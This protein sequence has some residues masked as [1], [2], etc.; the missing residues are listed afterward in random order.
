MPF[1]QPQAAAGHY[2]VVPVPA[3]VEVLNPDLNVQPE[4]QGSG[5]T[6]FLLRDV[7]ERLDKVDTGYQ[8]NVSRVLNTAGVDDNAQIT[9][10]FDPK[11]E[12]LH[13]HSVQVRRAGKSIDELKLGRIRVLQQEDE[14]ADNIVNGALTF[15]LLLTD[16]RVGDVIDSSY[17]ID[18][19]EPAWQDKHSGSIE[20]QWSTLIRRTRSRISLPVHSTL[21]FRARPDVA[22]RVWERDGYKFY[23]WDQ[24][25]A[26]AIAF[27]RQA[28]HWIQQFGG[29]EYSQFADWAEVIRTALPLFDVSAGQSGEIQQLIARFKKASEDPQA[30]IIAAMRFVQDEIRYTGIEEGIAAY[31]P[32]P[33]Q[34]V[35]ARRFGDCKDKTLL[36][37]TLLRGLGIE[38]APALVSTHWLGETRNRLPSPQVMD[39]AIV[40]IHWAG[41]VYWFDATATG[42]GGNLDTVWQA[43]F[44]WALPIDAGMADLQAMAE[45]ELSE[46]VEEV[47]TSVDM[48][49]GKDKP[50]Q[51]KVTTVYSRNEADSMRLNLRSEGAEALAKKYLDYYQDEFDGVTSSA[52]LKVTDDRS[53]N[54]LSVEE[55]Y[56]VQKIFKK[57]ERGPS[58]LYL[59]PDS[60]RSYLV[61]PNLK[62]RTTPFSQQYPIYVAEQFE[63]LFPSDWSMSASKQHVHNAAFD[64]SSD[65]S[66]SDRRL[67]TRYEYKALSD[68]V[69][70]KDFPEFLT[71]QKKARDDAGYTVRD[72][73]EDASPMPPAAQLQQTQV[74]LMPNVV[75]VARLI[76]LCAALI[77]V[78]Y[79]LIRVRA[80]RFR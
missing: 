61:A 35:L 34:E 60:L 28:P 5:G 63:V 7:Q 53:L 75:P 10:T 43:R 14:L 69:D 19:H 6:E 16:L 36:A 17:S 40:Q 27:E 22:P 11:I 48:R 74:F 73:V 64:Y 57:A 38:A 45:P 58:K 79:G 4:T 72:R 39:H 25:N 29:I 50:A 20:T 62:R 23:E 44:G 77:A 67:K 78:I 3:W 15:H 33:P 68:H 26:P 41:K 66:Y 32:T 13:L 30:R 12:K 8:H 37:V 47:S 31:R 18:R 71:A 54:R 2:D 59:E 46:P 51:L 42:Q 55:F 70:A 56:S 9:V 65:E 49:N 52:P 1:G 24:D 21:Y 76:M 80:G